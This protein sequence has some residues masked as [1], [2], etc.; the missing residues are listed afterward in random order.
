M[1]HSGVARVTLAG[2]LDLDTASYVREAVT[3]SLEERPTGLCLD[4]TGVSFC[5]CAGLS[6]LLRA[7]SSVLRA[8]VEFVVEGVGP[9][10][11]RLLSL[12]GAAG[13]FTGTN[14]PANAEPARRA[15]GTVTI[16]LGTEAAAT[17]DSP[18]P[19]LLA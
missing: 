10:L 17:A 19:D 2:E 12:I 16:L 6:A 3:A 18:L 4:L 11:E 13:L 15:P 9:Q 5:D 14:T 1:V 8:G 7:R